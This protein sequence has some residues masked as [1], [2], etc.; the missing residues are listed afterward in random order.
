MPKVNVEGVGTVNF[1][2]DMSEEEITQAI[3]T[4]ILPQ[5][6]TQAAPA[7]PKPVA[8][9]PDIAPDAPGALARVGRGAVDVKEGVQQRILQGVRK[10]PTPDVSIQELRAYASPEEQRLSDADLMAKYQSTDIAQD[11][12]DRANDERALYEKGRGPDP[13]FDAWRMV[14]NIAASSPAML[15]GRSGPGIINRAIQGAMQG[16]AAGATQ[17]SEKNSAGEVIKD[18]ALGAGIGAVAAPVVGAIADKT[19]AAIASARARSAGVTA[20]IRGLT[21]PAAIINQVPEMA[22]L[23]DEQLQPLLREA[24]DYIAR[25]GE[26]DAAQFARK[27]NLIRQGL[28]P[29]KAMVTRNARDWSIEENLRRAGTNSTDDVLGTTAQ[30]LTDL[31]TSNDA[32]LAERLRSFGRGGPAGSQEAQ[33]Q[34]VMEA[35]DDLATASQRQVSDLYDTVRQTSGDQLASD[36]RNL[37]NTLDDLRDNTYAEKL[38]SS[39][40]NK[41]RRF[42]MLD[43]DGNLT[44]QSLTVTQAEELRKFVN[45]LPNDYGKRDI[46]RAI[47]SDVMLG[48]GSDAFSSARGAAQ[49]RFRML[50]N[51]AT[52]RALDALGELAQG[53]NAQGFI[54]NHV[55]NAP[56]QDL[57]SLMSTLSNLP[58]DRAAGATSAI[59]SGVL[60]HLEQAA[61][62]VNSGQFSGA[63]F[64]KALEKIGNEKLAMVFG[65]DL[66]QLQQFARAALDAT[67]APPYSAVNY[68]N[69]GTLLAS[70][71]DRFAKSMSYG[72]AT[73]LVGPMIEMGKQISAQNA[74]QQALAQALAAQIDTPVVEPG[75][76]A[77]A[78][79]RALAQVTPVTLVSAKKEKERS[80]R[81]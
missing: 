9:I 73:P 63:N 77:R 67:Y 27:A 53:K 29:T 23:P 32:A 50:G 18:T 39:V 7:A 52:Q 51:P 45:T 69:S 78:L 46:I 80:A 42:G 48:F 31:R 17:F 37:A 56:A 74:R 8:A 5:Y 79:A 22:G 47:D 24:Q 1:P 16:G 26:L 58:A 40:S 36:A 6:E 55:V 35:L 72:R 21:Q 70:L 25:T 14:G 68:S 54:R 43:A 62:N 15:I 49:Q 3:E 10:L 61:V 57:R 19:G 65:D 30:N 12:T 71:G 81:K 64:N 41:L 59:R 33:G 76:T 28:Q 11:F 60:D 44:N 13:G 34:R 38:V 66:P 4:E 20:S 2:D 75:Q